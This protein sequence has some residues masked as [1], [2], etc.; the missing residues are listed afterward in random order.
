MMG[1]DHIA[2]FAILGI[3]QFVGILFAMYLAK[4]IICTREDVKDILKILKRH[5]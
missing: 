2:A 5:P 4:C 3:A 1:W